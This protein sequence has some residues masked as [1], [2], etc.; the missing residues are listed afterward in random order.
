MNT[1]KNPLIRP[2]GEVR[3]LSSE[4]LKSF[5]P[6]TETLPAA[7]QQKLGMRGRGPQR[8]PTKERITIRLSPE[9]VDAFRASGPGWQGRIDDALKSWLKR[10]EPA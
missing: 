8:S 10:H 1:A 5:R 9:V 2:D 6:A 4:D 3:E 7:L